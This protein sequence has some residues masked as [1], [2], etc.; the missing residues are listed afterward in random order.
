MDM[1]EPRLVH[2]RAL[3]IEWG[4]CDPAGI[5]F[6][7]RYFAMFDASTA[8]LFQAALGMPKIA[9]TA[10][11]GILGIPMVDTRAKFHVPAVYG[12]EVVIESRITA[13]RRSS[14]DVTHRL[15]KAD[16]ALGVEGFETRVWTVR[17]AEGGRIRSAP[18]PEEVLA[19]FA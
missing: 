12:D 14:F 1:A 4:D 9:W 3:T 13:F 8:A 18:I 19:A 15:L 10:R 17:E 7:P 2:R 5:V 11:F 6:Y 16:G